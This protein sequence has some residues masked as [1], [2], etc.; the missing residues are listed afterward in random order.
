MNRREEEKDLE[1]VN[2]ALD[3][4]MDFLEEHTEFEINIWVSAMASAIA[5][6]FKTS[7][8]SYEQFKEEM[9]N[10]TNFYGRIWN[11]V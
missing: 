9:Q 2:S 10:M 7:G 8:F 11:E 4:L 1:Q 3:I 5:G 6:S